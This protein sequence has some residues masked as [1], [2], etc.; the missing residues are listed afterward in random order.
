L[1]REE[2]IFSTFDVAHYRPKERPNAVRVVHQKTGEENWIPLIDAKGGPLYP[3]LMGELDA[4][5]DASASADSCCA[6]TGAT[7]LPGRPR[8]AA[9]PSCATRRRRSSAPPG[10]ATN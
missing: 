10:G 6:A 7:A 8:K 2:D 1:Q 5:S 3:E 9:R 4:P